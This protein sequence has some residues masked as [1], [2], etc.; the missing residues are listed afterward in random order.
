MMNWRSLALNLSVFISVWSA[1][2]FAII[3]MVLMTTLVL[4]LWLRLS[5]LVEGGLVLII[6]ATYAGTLTIAWHSHFY[7]LMPLIPLLIYLHGRRMLPLSVQSAWL[8]GPPLWYIL[9]YL[10]NPSSARNWFGLGML[11]LSLLLAAWASLRLLNSTDLVEG[12]SQ[13]GQ[14]IGP[15]QRATEGKRM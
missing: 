10:I 4:Y 12:G 15:V 3:G 8:L 2:S 1:W 5:K 14:D 9:V 13:N 7:L 11:A 6:L